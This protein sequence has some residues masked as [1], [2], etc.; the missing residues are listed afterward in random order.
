MWLWLKK[1]LTVSNKRQIRSYLVLVYPFG[2]SN[3]LEPFASKII[4][5]PNQSLKILQVNVQIEMCA[6]A[7]RAVSG[8]FPL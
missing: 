8:L 6:A 1:E 3:H 7:A 5:G 2:W 4:A